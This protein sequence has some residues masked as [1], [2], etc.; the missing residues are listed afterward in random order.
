[1][2]VGARRRRCGVA[3]V[4]VVGALALASG[5]GSSG[6]GQDAAVVTDSHRSGEA[7]GALLAR[8]SDTTSGVET[9]RVRVSYNIRGS[10][11]GQDIDADMVA[12]G[13]FADFGRSMELTLDMTPMI[14]S[15][16]QSEPGAPTS[17]I[18]REIVAG[19]DMYMKIEATPALP[20]LDSGQWMHMDL[21][22]YMSDG[23][24]ANA[25]GGM[26]SGGPNGY[27]E[28]L[29]ASGAT[30]TEKG[31]DEIDGVAVT[32][33]EGE[34]DPE[35]AVEQAP[36]D[37]AD[38]LRRAFR[39]SGMGK[40]P[41]TVYIDDD[42]LVRRMDMTMTMGMAGS[43]M[44]MEMSM[45]LYDF[46]APVSVTPPPGDEVVEGPTGLAALGTA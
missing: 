1:M 32:V 16:G 11:A 38:E 37:K 9:G 15:M 34:I 42:G 3:T 5:C 35:S 27:L 46:G 36:A 25:F 20:G 30:V 33:L 39:E 41:F 2:R 22:Q 8:A 13:N 7:A 44:Q 31:R 21:G 40:V 28:S 18:M 23:A 29:K 43:S 10:S 26:M 12:K 19:P 24:A 17:M 6:S 4:A 14:A 45:D